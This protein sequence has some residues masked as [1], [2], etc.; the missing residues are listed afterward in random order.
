MSLFFMSCAMKV[1]YN[2]VKEKYFLNKHKYVDFLELFIKQ[3]NIIKFGRDEEWTFPLTLFFTENNIIYSID[4]KI[5]NA[6]LRFYI[7]NKFKDN[8]N[9]YWDKYREQI[10]TNNIKYNVTELLTLNNITYDEFDMLRKFFSE[11]KFYSISRYKFSNC[12]ILK[13]GSLDGIIYKTT[14]CVEPM[15]PSAKEIKQIDENIYYFKEY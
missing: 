1:S 8:E 5:N 12:V 14:D 4:T 9:E 2:E 11:N 7:D 10:K 13:F 6:N 15:Y 3:D